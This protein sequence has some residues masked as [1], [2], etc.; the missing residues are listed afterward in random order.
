[1]NEK[2]DELEKYLSK[3]SEFTLPNFNEIPDGV[4][5]EEVIKFLS[6]SLASFYN[7]E[8]NTVT[9]YMVNNYVKAKVIPSPKDKEYTRVQ[10][11]YM[12]FISLLKNTTSLR[13]IASFIS[14]DKDFT[15]N[16]EDLY[17]FY[18]KMLDNSIND[19]NENVHH[20]VEKVVSETDD[21]KVLLRLA[22]A[23]LKLYIDSSTQKIVA[24]SIMK[25]IND[26]VLPLNAQKE[27]K[28]EKALEKKKLDKEAKL[29][30]SRKEG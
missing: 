24:D 6:S 21:K 18:Q 13:N 4:K 12:F 10:I 2:L 1:M 20:T 30:S 29:L 28:Q 25:L 8:E 11:G 19:V 15:K 17:G 16:K 5:M 23:A 9:N 7:D 27:A 26:E 3:L 22:Y 14:L